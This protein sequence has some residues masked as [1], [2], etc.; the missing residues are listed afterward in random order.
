NT[1]EYTDYKIQGGGKKLLRWLIPNSM[2][3]NCKYVYFGDVDILILREND[4]LND[5]H[6]TQLNKL[7]LPFSNKVRVD[8]FNKP[9]KRMTGLHFID[10]INYYK[11]IQPIIDKIKSD[12]EY[13]KEYLADLHRDE[14]LLYKMNKEAFMFDEKELIHAKRPWHGLHLGITR[15]NKNI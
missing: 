9:V 1:E 13:R 6:I 14:N 10:V 2:F 8:S 11:T 7:N 15:G 5:F 3:T 12:S 4:Q